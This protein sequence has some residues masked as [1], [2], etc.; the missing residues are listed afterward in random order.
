GD[1]NA[2][3]LNALNQIREKL[4][5]PDINEYF[6]M[7]WNI[8]NFEKFVDKYPDSIQKCDAF[9]FLGRFYEDIWND[10][11]LKVLKENER[12][13]SIKYYEKYLSECPSGIWKATVQYE[14]SQVKNNKPDS[15]KYLID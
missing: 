14:L 10:S 13:K 6:K 8:D 15:R 3:I 12:K 7:D 4:Y 2:G 5:Q 9:M 11:I 1:F